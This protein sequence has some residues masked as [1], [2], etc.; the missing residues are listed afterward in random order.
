MV[1]KELEAEEV[2]N[3]LVLYSDAVDFLQVGLIYLYE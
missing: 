1:L 2:M 3:I